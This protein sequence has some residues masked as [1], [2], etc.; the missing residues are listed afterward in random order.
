[1]GA[2]A[3]SAGAGAAMTHIPR[4][5]QTRTVADVLAA[6]A[7][8]VRRVCVVAP[9][10]AGKTTI[11]TMLAVELGG[12]GL[13][14]ADRIELIDQ[15]AA[16]L[17]DAGLDVACVS[18]QH[19][20]DPWAPVQVASLDTLV[21]RGLRP[22]AEWVVYDETHHICAETYSA[23]IGSYPDARLVGLTAT[24]SR[25]D[26][27][28]LTGYY[29]HLVIAAS[30]SELLA[31][32]HLVRCRRGGASEAEGYL[33]R[34][35]AQEPLA[36]W[37]QMPEG[38]RQTI[39]FA[40]S[41]EDAHKWTA[42]FNAAGI[43]SACVEGNTSDDERRASLERF[44]AGEL[45][46]LWNVYCLTEGT[47]LPM[48]SCVLLARGVPGV[49]Q[50]L[51]MTGRGLRPY[52]GKRDMRLIDLSG[53]YWLHGSPTADREYALDGRP[54]RLTGEPL[55]NCPQCGSCI[56]AAQNPCPDCGYEWP[57]V[58]RPKLKIFDLAL[59][60]EIE[61]AGG[62]EHV[63]DEAKR[64]E[65]DRLMALVETREKWSV[66]FARREYEK[67]FGEPPPAEWVSG[68]D[69]TVR[70]RE[71]AKLLRVAAA[72]KYKPQWA[73]YRFKHLFHRW[74]STAE[75]VAA[76]GAGG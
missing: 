4:P 36:A 3:L 75:M 16:R 32:G 13:W 17:R 19:A 35:I 41:V 59:Q 8:G 2:V 64:R 49:E 46:V 48:V 42:Q 56:P 9:P 51:Q 20:P 68:A 39:A 40:P 61:Q 43:P 30:Y 44:R 63:S 54:I 45:M 50:F 52:P 18:P 28:A 15:A 47:D 11:G 65:W 67:L 6:Y 76:K 12:R 29:D 71:L 37:Q 69:A 23:V 38:P 33:G 57:A 72:K 60:W 66:G 70:V 53:A 31:A 24:P 14:L 34:G 21:A 22:P 10:G 26:G 73:A 5:Y 27:K 7:E 25:G 62:I 1:M 58:E 55:K 74:P